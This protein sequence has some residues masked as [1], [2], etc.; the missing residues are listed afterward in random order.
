MLWL[1]AGAAAVL[2]GPARAVVLWS[3]LGATLAHD[4]GVGSD[5][6]GGAV[7]RDDTAS[8]TLYF[9]FHVDPISDVGTE[10]YSAGFQ[11]YEGEAERL[12]VGNSLK[13]WAYSAFNTAQMGPS[14]TV[15]GDF[16]LNSSRPESPRAGVFLPYELPRHGYDRTIVF[17]VEYVAG[18]DDRV[19]VWLNPDLAPGATEASQLESLTT[20]FTA[21]ASFN[22]VHL[23]HGGG[24]GGWTFSDMAIATSFDDFVTGASAE[25]GG[26]A[27]GGSP[28]TLTFRSWQRE[29]GLPQ[30]SVR[31]L[32]QT[33]DGYLWVG[34]EDGVARFDGVR[35]VSFG[36][37]EGLRGGSVRAL[38]EDSRGAL[39]IGTVGGGLTRWQ[40]GQFTT[41]TMR[42]GLPVDS[43][44]AL[45]KIGKDVYGS[46]PK[47]ALPSGKTSDLRPWLVATSRAESS[48]PCSRT[49]KESCGSA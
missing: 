47:P 20:R 46:G 37:R 49:G 3:D 5:V 19:T 11:L 45:G 1:L 36:L 8:D 6:L 43:I 27:A 35:F 7:K 17:K 13:A 25:P 32:A 38:L 40:D 29:Q 9:K 12:A 44:T 39:W 15:A 48:P 24:G 26:A 4:T 18:G 41:F 22:E 21:N 30:T 10:E 34:S 2:P 42:D 23:R 14:N 28:Q 33:R 31:A 16:D